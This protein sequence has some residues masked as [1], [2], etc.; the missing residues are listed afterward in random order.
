MF[1]RSTYPTTKYFILR[2]SLSE[3]HTFMEDIRIY[4]VYIYDGYA[5]ASCVQNLGTSMP[6]YLPG[7]RIYCV[8][9]L[10]AILRV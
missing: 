2:D 3:A 10:K 7:G 5:L 1:K 6:K 4:Y 8:L 9:I